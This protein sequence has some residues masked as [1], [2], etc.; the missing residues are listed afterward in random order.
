M[1][2]KP[3]QEIVITMNRNVA[4]CS[5]LPP[6]L[7]PMFQ[8]P[9]RLFRYQGRTVQL[10]DT[11]SCLYTAEKNG[12]IVLPSGSVE[13]LVPALQQL[14]YQV[15]VNDLTA[16]PEVARD[17]DQA[18]YQQLPP[19]QQRR[20]DLIISRR[21]FVLQATKQAAVETMG[22][23]ASL[24][25]KAKILIVLPRTTA[26]ACER[27]ILEM[28]NFVGGNIG[29]AIGLACECSERV[30]IASYWQFAVSSASEWSIVLFPDV[31]RAITNQVAEG[32]KLYHAN[33]MY[34]FITSRKDLSRRSVLRLEWLAGPIISELGNLAVA[35]SV[36]AIFCASKM[37]PLRV[38]QE[39]LARKRAGIWHIPAKQARRVWRGHSV[40]KLASQ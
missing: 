37:R 40:R 39:P 3:A 24:Y 16:L 17:H 13:R 26:T 1:Q 23:I 10:R 19:E 5:Q 2:S 38:P 12:S 30:A 6:S 4:S 27:T 22:L 21:Q 9:E 14:G 33:R 15:A 32:A 35:T 11:D 25:R 31:D 8:H 29:R 20:C 7:L 28:A 18:F 36:T 34:G